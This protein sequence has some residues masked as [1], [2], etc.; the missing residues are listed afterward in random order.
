MN[1]TNCTE[2]WVLGQ[3]DQ[4][5]P[6]AHLLVNRLTEHALSGAITE[7]IKWAEH[8]EEALR[9]KSLVDAALR[10]LRFRAEWLPAQDFRNVCTLA[11]QKILGNKAEARAYIKCCG[12]RG[13][14]P[15]PECI[16]RIETLRALQPG[17]MCAD[18]TWGFGIVQSVDPLREKIQ[19]DFEKK[20]GHELAMSYAAEALDIISPDHLLGVRHTNPDQITQWLADDPAAIVRLALHSYGP[21]SPAQL[22]DKL[23]PA[24]V[25]A[26]DW[27]KFWERARKA[28]KQDPEARIPT[29]RSEPI[30]LKEAAAAY[31]E[32]WFRQLKLQRDIEVIL[33]KISEWMALH[34]PAAATPTERA[35]FED[36]LAFA[37]KGADLMGNTLLPRAMMLAH[38]LG[39]PNGTLGVTAYLDNLLETGALRDVLE[40]LSAKDM[41]AFVAFLIAADRER[42]LSHLRRLLAQLDVTALGEVLQVLIR[43][44]GEDAC[45]A[46]IKGLLNSRRAEVEICSWL[47]RNLDLLKSWALCTPME[48]AEIMLLEM[49]KDYSGNRLKAQNQ[50][51]DRFTQKT[52]VKQLFN[53]LGPTGRENYFMRLKD[54]NAWPTMEKRSALGLIIKQYP[55]LEKCMA[56]R[57]GDKREAAVARGPVTSMRSYRERELLAERIKKVDIPN[58]SKE[59]AV[60]RAHGDLREN[61]EYQAA[62]DAQG[63]LMRRQAELQQMLAKVVPTDFASMPSDKVGPGTGVSLQYADGRQES[64]FIL[65][66]WDRDEALHIISCDSKLAQALEGSAPGAEVT[67][68]TEDGQAICRVTSVTGLSPAVQEWLKA[69][70]EA[71]VSAAA[72]V[73]D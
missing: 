35:V 49:E 62:K 32:A 31:N 3:V 34:D 69:V 21:L 38:A 59:I 50:L 52:W 42:A 71:D 41:K 33:Q 11:L 68:P 64:Y 70:P 48:F 36:R 47:S 10:L 1:E 43:E 56:G 61:F 18:K 39:D 5:E 24:I 19:I 54:S 8:A 13:R 28:L 6:D 60:A 57:S 16:D 15:L 25:S 72:M 7:A 17:A 14:V 67:V 26:A 66:V 29:K 65:G 12:L 20:P 55:E 58:N 37:I 23:V 27:K 45:M 63:L 51:R 53:E 44:G 4:A 22:Q 73:T 9:D 40:V 30:L 2:E 46:E